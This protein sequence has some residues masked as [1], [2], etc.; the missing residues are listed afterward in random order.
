MSILISD[1]DGT[2]T[3]YD[4]F[5]RVRQRWP[6]PPQDDPWEKFVTGEITHFQALAE[7]FA[8]IRTTEAHASDI[9]RARAAPVVSLRQR[10]ELVHQVRGWYS[11]VAIKMGRRQGATREHI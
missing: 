9:L 2:V 6:F 5:D 10:H 3:R 11:G 8:S 7:I 4:F 1:F